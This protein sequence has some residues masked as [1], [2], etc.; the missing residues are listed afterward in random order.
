MN[1]ECNGCLEP[2]RH[3]FEQDFH[4]RDVCRIVAFREGENMGAD[5]VRVVVNYP[6]AGVAASCRAKC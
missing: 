5:A 3:V 6:G 1:W 4:G 2:V